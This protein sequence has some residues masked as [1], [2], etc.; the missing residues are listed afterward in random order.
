ME[1]LSNKR[2]SEYNFHYQIFNLRIRLL[3]NYM[4][5]LDKYVGNV[6]TKANLFTPNL[7]RKSEQKENDSFIRTNFDQVEEVLF[8][9]EFSK[10]TSQIYNIR[11]SDFI[12]K[13]ILK[14]PRLNIK[15]DILYKAIN[16]YNRTYTLPR[17]RANRTP[18]K[19]SILSNHKLPSLND[20]LHTVVDIG[21]R[22]RGF[23]SFNGMGKPCGNALD[24]LIKILYEKAEFIKEDLKEKNVKNRLLA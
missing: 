14:D 17:Q 3:I 11:E 10:I 7:S 1:N 13:Y 6:I 16:I 9:E 8:S 15:A 5:L 2:E 12:P 23:D 24:L 20:I 18:I 19:I 21:K 22:E 4:V